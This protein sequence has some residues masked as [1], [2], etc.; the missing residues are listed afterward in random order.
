MYSLCPTCEETKGKTLGLSGKTAESSSRAEKVQTEPGIPWA[1]KQ[2][3]DQRFNGVIFKRHENWKGISLAIP[4]AHLSWKRIKI[5]METLMHVMGEK[6][7]WVHSDTPKKRAR[8]GRTQEK[9]KER[10][11]SFDQRMPA[12][13]CRRNDTVRKLSQLASLAG[14]L[15]GG[16]A[17]WV[18]SHLSLWVSISEPVPLECCS[19]VYFFESLYL[20]VSLPKSISG[21]TSESLT[22]SLYLCVNPWSL[23]IS[24]SLYQWVY[25]LSLYI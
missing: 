7:P 16:L 18:S 23:Y 2:E 11:I 8:E 20:W 5:I 21:Y 25:P 10:R 12:N 4:G 15:A 14:W 17:S 22:E 19:H 9:K 1:R 13:K 3:T 6:N 24:E